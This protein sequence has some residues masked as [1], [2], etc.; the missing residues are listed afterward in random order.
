M[1]NISNL[2]LVFISIYFGILLLVGYLSSRKQKD[3]DY[4]IAERKLGVFSTMATINA[5]KTGS[6]LMIF[7]AM[8]YIAGISALWYFV[9]MTLGILVFI[10][11]GLRL[12]EYSHKKF[13]TLADYFKHN[14]GKQ[15]GILAGAM[16]VF[17]MFGLLVLNLIAATKI[18]V[19]FTGWPFWLCAIIVA[20]IVLSYL[21][22]GGFRAVVKTD[23][24]QYIA[25][26][27]I[28]GVLTILTFKSSLISSADWN[29]FNTDISTLA[30]F[31]IMGVLYPFAMPELWQRVYSAKDKITLKK[32]LLA[33][34]LIYFIF[35]LFLGL[36]A[37][38][39]KAQFPNIDPDIALIHGFKNLLSPGLLGLSMVL[40][41]SAIRPVRSS[42][43]SKPLKNTI[44]FNN[45]VIISSSNG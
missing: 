8:V 29:L 16:T 24:I 33:S 11:F 26:I 14:Y 23:V 10:P 40:L 34:A 44:L 4:L 20:F 43:T 27:F 36:A 35:A 37:L 13:Y 2:D 6:I 1:I 28:L 18:F 41:F 39:I 45:S 7:V 19:F 15:A 3:D 38:G 9:G 12:K 32:G 31:F 17:L 25:M 42:I 30:G 22:M 21:L 5:S